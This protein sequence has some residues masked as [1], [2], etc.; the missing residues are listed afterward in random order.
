[1]SAY[2]EFDPTP[3]L[4]SPEPGGGPAKVAKPAKVPGGRG[5]QG[6]T[7]ATLATLAAS[8]PDPFDPPPAGHAP[9]WRRWF[10]LLVRHK[11]EVLGRAE[12]RTPEDARRLAYGEALTAWHMQQAVRSTSSCCAG[13]GN[14]V[15]DPIHTLPDGAKVCPTDECLIA[16]GEK[17]RSAAAAGLAAM[18]IS[19]L[20]VPAIAQPDPQP[21]APWFDAGPDGEPLF[22]H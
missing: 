7:L 11:I 6:L 4:S 13:C 20:V 19:E 5:E 21:A 22:E 2:R 3:F 15:A 16:Y 9:E 10:A 8:P 18:G 1:M 12:S 17:W 14:P